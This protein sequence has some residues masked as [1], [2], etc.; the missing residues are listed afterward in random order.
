MLQ[1][2]RGRAFARGY[3][4]GIQEASHP[5]REVR[6]ACG[7]GETAQRRAHRSTRFTSKIGGRR[8]PIWW[9]SGSNQNLRCEPRDR[10][11]M[12][13]ARTHLALPTAACRCLAGTRSS[14]TGEEAWGAS[15]DW[16]WTPPSART[17]CTPYKGKSHHHRG[18][19]TSQW[20]Q[21]S[22]SAAIKGGQFFQLRHCAHISN[23][24]GRIGELSMT[25]RR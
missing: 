21:T 14:R 22:A 11:E 17:L 2:V 10:Q 4:S 12:R 9:F 1:A 6:R 18:C 24:W 19:K 8:Q 5:S 23:A 13:Y 25:F 15:A 3:P 20:D 16:A 7:S